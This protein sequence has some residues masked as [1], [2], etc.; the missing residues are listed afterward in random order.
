MF[1]RRSECWD[2]EYVD[3]AGRR[4]TISGARRMRNARGTNVGYTEFAS[5][6]EALE[7][8]GLTASPPPA[9]EMPSIDDENVVDVE[10]KTV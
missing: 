4:Y 10:T 7:A 5:L 9:P 1:Y 3:A 2:G 8:W 6:E